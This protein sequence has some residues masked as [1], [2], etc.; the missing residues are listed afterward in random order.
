MDVP[1]SLADAGLDL[2][3]AFDAAAAAREPGLA[4]LADP[5]RRL[6]LIVGNTSALW[7]RFLA[8]WRADR[9]LAA[10]P[11]PLDRYCARAIERAF[12]GEPVWLAHVAYDGAFVPIQ[13]LADLVGL[14]YLAPTHLSIHP[15]YGP[16]FALRAIIL[17][18]GDPPLHRA[19][20][21]PPCRCA[22]ACTSALER[23][24][25][26]K[27]PESWI[28]VRDACPIGRDHRY[29]DDQLLYHYTKDRAL[30]R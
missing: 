8:A 4:M 30:L 5:A 12:T 16:W 15:T 29:S 2:V 10:D 18:H 28:A 13:R 27:D 9:E 6:G 7:P 26:S 3:H 19:R 14:A 21:V 22:A 11:H 23:A 1:A 24:M 17:L 20:A 25:S